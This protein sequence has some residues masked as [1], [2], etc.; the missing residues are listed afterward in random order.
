ME[1]LPRSVSN[2]RLIPWLLLALGL[3]CTFWYWHHETTRDSKLTR[4]Q[5]HELTEALRATVRYRLEVHADLP[6]V[7]AAWFVSEKEVSAKDWRTFAAA[8]TP[9][10]R[11]PGWLEL[12]FVES[13]NE[14]DRE[15][16]EREM[17]QLLGDPSFR[18]VSDEARDS[19]CTVTY[20]QALETDHLPFAPGHD[21]ASEKRRRQTLRQSADSGLPLFSPPFVRTGQDGVTRSELL[22]FT[23]VYR[24]GMP[25]TDTEERRHAL[26]GWVAVVY[27]VRL[28]FQ[29]LFRNE[30]DQIRVEI[31]DGPSLRST[32]L[33]FD[34]HPD[35]PESVR[36]EGWSSVVRGA[37][38]G[39]GWTYRFSPGP[40]F[41][42]YHSKRGPVIVLIAGG[43]ISLA[44]GFAG[45]SLTSSR[46]RALAQAVAMTRAHR[47]S[48]ERLRRTVLH[49]PIPIMIHAADGHVILVNRRWC[50]RSGHALD[51]L[52]TL[53]EW[54]E[55]AL[56]REE[57]TKAL[58]LLD[59]TFPADAPFKEGELVILPISGERRVWIVRS[60]PIGAMDN[61][62]DLII[63]MAMDITE[64][65][66]AEETLL[67]AKLEAEE[68][69]R[70]KSEFLATMSH[71]IRTPMNVIVGMAEVLEETELTQEQRRYV[72]IFRRA[73]DSLLELIND[74]LDLSKVEAGR[75]ELELAPF[76][77]RETLQRILDIMGM[78]A[79][80]KGL[81]I[82]LEIDDAVPDGLKG[83]AKRLRQ[84]LINLIGN[85]VKFTLEGGIVIRVVCEP[86]LGVGGLSFAVRDTGIGIPKEKHAAVF[87]AFTQAD[88][89]TTRQFGGTGLG[90]AISR[91]LVD[92]MGGQMTLESAPGQGS[93]FRFTALFALVESAQP[94][95]PLPLDERDW[96]QVCVLVVDERAESRLALTRLVAGLGAK[97]EP[98][99]DRAMV[100]SAWRAARQAGRPCRLLVV[101]CQEPEVQ[102][103][104]RIRHWR[105][106]LEQPELPVIVVGSGS[107]VP[108]LSGLSGVRVLAL[109]VK[110]EAL[111]VALRALLPAEP[112]VAR[113]VN[114]EPV[115]AG[116]GL[117]ILV[118]DD[119][120]DNILLVKA[121]LKKTTHR[122][123]VSHNGQEAVARITAGERFDV[124]LMDV[125]MPV[126]DGYAAT[127]AIRAW[128]MAQGRA[129][130]PVIALTAH[131]F[132]ENER[133][134]LEA[135]CSEHL[136]KPI[137]KPRLLAALDRYAGTGL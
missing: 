105:G 124:V 133:Q 72:G 135:G 101:S 13:V 11:H 60:R 22:Y 10:G 12:A 129:A 136:T 77:L 63:S 132:A 57:R 71:E 2:P 54:V 131:A 44:L 42:Q 4:E 51:E 76:P 49:A 88:A 130:V 96:S 32:A 120:E 41:L 69:N 20:H 103:E 1:T 56:P 113:V 61:P 27:D 79:R 84:I 126:M 73:G 38:E 3:A 128:E 104:E 50:E 33:I 112:V 21:L 59:A 122:L 97:V 127:R 109:P 66:K 121:F 52:A 62:G 93:T 83:D 15:G 45:W 78:R 35:L 26:L 23:P 82:T 34:S 28:L 95:L 115:V 100:G 18:I 70:A 74:I 7:M 80:E 86:G 58:E 118:V 37:D 116:R 99:P 68:A 92:L 9:K 16:F 64:R 5:F 102:L 98:V 30:S 6:R 110:R 90:L 91:R 119:S 137:T 25:V 67:E 40:V 46:E 107:L 117:D 87:D 111:A 39:G 89:S 17:R 29:D 48:E 8:L 123:S 94:G 36:E 19:Y 31:F 125:Q 47:E 106:E 14:A 65:K 55:R 24:L 134:T 85:A 114:P 81:S 108:D 43:L 75:M 53:H